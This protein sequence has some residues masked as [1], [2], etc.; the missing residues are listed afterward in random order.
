MCLKQMKQDSTVNQ[1]NPEA[2][3][4]IGRVREALHNALDRIAELD[5]VLNMITS[6]QTVNP[7]KMIKMKFSHSPDFRSV[8]TG[9][10]QYS[11]TTAQAACIQVLYEQCKSKTP[12]ISGAYILETINYCS[13]R[14]SDLFKGHPAWGIL[15]VSGN[16]RGTYRLNI[17]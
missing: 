13:Q 3:Q 9:G 17:T 8:Y 16:T 10:K 7:P 1:L 12:E 6:N 11:F 14:L 4:S 5:G 15:I 2:L